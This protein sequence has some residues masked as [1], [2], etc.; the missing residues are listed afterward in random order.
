M[1][2]KSDLFIYGVGLIFFLALVGV[3]VYFANKKPKTDP[4]LCYEQ[5]TDGLSRLVALTGDQGKTLQDIV[6]AYNNNTLQ[7][8][9]DMNDHKKGTELAKENGYK[10]L[11]A[12]VQEGDKCAYHL[13]LRKD[14]PED[15]D[16]QVDVKYCGYTGSGYDFN[17]GVKPG[18]TCSTVTRV[19]GQP[20]IPTWR[21]YDLSA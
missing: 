21:Y 18:T 1:G 13:Y 5:V 16:K 9:K 3:V 6:D 11:M 17:A 8:Y 10:Y 20:D 19:D 14:L 12:T 15:S 7:Y 4:E 2:T